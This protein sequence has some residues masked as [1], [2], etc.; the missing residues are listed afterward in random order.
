[1]KSEA[2]CSGVANATN[3]TAPAG[4]CVMR[5]ASMLAMAATTA[6]AATHHRPG[7]AIA[8]ATPMMVAKR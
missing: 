4:G 2:L 8:V 6:S 7:K 5:S 3:G 1:M